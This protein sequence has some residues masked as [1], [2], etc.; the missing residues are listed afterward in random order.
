MAIKNKKTPALKSYA[1]VNDILH[2]IAALQLTVDKKENDLNA[3]IHKLTLEYEPD[4]K[5]LKE[6]ILVLEKQVEEYCICHKNDFDMARSKEFTIGRYGFRTGKLSLQLISKKFTWDRVLEKVKDIFGDKY[7]NIV[8]T[9]NKTKLLKD[10]E[11][12]ILS[13]EAL[14]ACGCKVNKG[15]KFFYEIDYTKIKLEDSL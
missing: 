15:E 6:K 5:I 2:N 11:K 7:V 1:E 4:I 13:D 3:R 12:D 14:K 8:T 10:V 9:L